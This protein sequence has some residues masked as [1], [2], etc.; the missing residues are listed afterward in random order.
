MDGVVNWYDEQQGRGFITSSDGSD[1]F[2]YRTALDFLTLL[3]AGDHVEYD[4]A[5]EPN[6]PHAIN[7]KVLDS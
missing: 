4:V 3:H 2:V 7:V 5:P 6:G 1:V